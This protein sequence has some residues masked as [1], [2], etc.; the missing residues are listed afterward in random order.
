MCV[1]TFFEVLF[2]FLILIAITSP[3]ITNDK[4]LQN[5]MIALSYKRY[6]Y[7]INCCESLSLSLS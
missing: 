7:A 4:L 3:Y 5:T 1:F 2:F 6:A